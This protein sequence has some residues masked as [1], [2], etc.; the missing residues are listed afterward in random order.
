MK[1]QRTEISTPE[2]S[3]GKKRVLGWHLLPFQFFVFFIFPKLVD[4]SFF[5]V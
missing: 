4:F 1:Y 5:Y 2:K 3:M